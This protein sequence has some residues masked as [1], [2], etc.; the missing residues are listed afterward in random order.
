V[1][2][3]GEHKRQTEAP[4]YRR[5]SGDA[6]SLQGFVSTCRR[7]NK[8]NG[9]LAHH[10]GFQPASAGFVSVAGSL[11]GPAGARDMYCPDPKKSFTLEGRESGPG[12]LVWLWS[13]QMKGV[14]A[15]RTLE[16]QRRGAP[17][18]SNS[19]HGNHDT[20]KMARFLN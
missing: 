11:Q 4:L 10:C 16:L 15:T 20:N 5:R 3:E 9:L 14:A 2:H 19:S 18:Q 7:S 1:E 8:M 6:V 12:L 17:A 13:Q